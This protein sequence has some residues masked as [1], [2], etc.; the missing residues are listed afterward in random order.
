MKRLGISELDKKWLVLQKFNVDRE[1]KEG[2]VE[3]REGGTHLNKVAEDVPDLSVPW[4]PV[5]AAQSSQ[6]HLETLQRDTFLGLAR[7]IRDFGGEAQPDRTSSSFRCTLQ[8]ENHRSIL[9]LPQVWDI[10]ETGDISK[11]ELFSLK[12]KWNHCWESYFLFPVFH[13]F[14]YRGKRLSFILVGL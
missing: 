2:F 11:R 1:G 3:G 12:T 8:S 13:G 4:F 7:W 9:S 5:A 6:H 10:N 14:W